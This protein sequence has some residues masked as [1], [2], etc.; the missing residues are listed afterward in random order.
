M[1][2]RVAFVLAS[3]L[4]PCSGGLAQEAPRP[5]ARPTRVVGWVSDGHCG[6]AHMKPGGADNPDA[7]WGH[8]S[9]QLE[10]L[11]TLND[12]KKSLKVGKLLAVKQR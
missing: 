6:A 12:E 11:A 4:L 3:S 5:P 10:I 7:L 8:E 1:R 2:Q 9:Q